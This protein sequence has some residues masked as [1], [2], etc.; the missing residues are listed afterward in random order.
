MLPTTARRPPT[1]RSTYICLSCRLHSNVSDSRSNGE[2]RPRKT[3]TR[4][5]TH[6]NGSTERSEDREVHS[7][8]AKKAQ[9]AASARQRMIKKREKGFIIK[10]TNASI[11]PLTKLFPVGEKPIFPSSLPLQRSDGQASY[12]ERISAAWLKRPGKQWGTAY[13]AKEAEML[14]ERQGG[15]KEELM[16][17]HREMS[18]GRGAE[19]RR[20]DSVEWEEGGTSM[21]ER[22]A[23]EYVERH[24]AGQENAWSTPLFWPTPKLSSH[25]R[26]T[27]SILD[28]A[29]TRHLH[30]S[31]CRSQEA[32]AA[33]AAATTTIPEQLDIPPPEPKKA[34]KIRT[35]LRQ[36][37][38]Q[39]GN[40]DD[41]KSDIDFD[42]DANTA[43]TSN[44]LT[45][46]PD[47]EA[48]F[49]RSDLEEKEEEN[50]SSYA[51][52]PTTDL[53][54][55]TLDTRF[56]QTGDLVELE[57]PQSERESILA[58]FV[59]RL[60]IESQFFTM[61]GRWVH[62]PER[63]VQYSI[64]G[65][66][67]PSLVAPLLDHLPNPST[68]EEVA[69]VKEIAYVQDLSVPR[70]LAAPL[71]SRMVAF[72]TE[73]LEIYRKHAGTLDNAHE[74]LAHETDLRY[75]SLIAAATT[76]L[77][78]PAEKLPVTALFTVRKALG[79]AGF[80]F[81]IDRR[82]HRLT[83]Y[84]QIRSKEQVKMVE[85]V[86]GW[87]REWQDDLAARSAL[88]AEGNERALK[89]HSTP[90]SALYV[91][92]FIEK[93]K[94]IIA[95]SRKDR[96]VTFSGNVGPSKKRFPITPH[97]D[98]V[99]TFKR[100]EFDEQDTE[101][102]R[103]M[104]AWCCS[105]MF[106]DLP[107]IAALPPLILQATGLYNSQE[108]GVATGYQF[109]QELGTIMPYENRVAFDQ[110]LLLP[111]SQH[112]KPLQNLMTSLLEMQDRH[113]FSDSMRE[114]RHD[115]GELSVYCIDAA[116]AHEIDDGLSIQ[117]ASGDEW[118]V[119]V[120]I[121]NPTAFFERDHPLAKMARHMG[122]SIYMPERAYMMLPRW[123]TSR[124]FSLGKN[125]PCLTFSARVNREGETLE[126]SIRP[127]YI[128]NV[129]RLTPE[130]VG[131]LTGD[132]AEGK[133]EEVVLTVGGDVPPPRPRKDV[134][135]SVTEAQVEE[136]KMLQK[137]AGKRSDI[138]R[139]SGGVFFD[140]HRPDIEVWQTYKNPGLPWDHPYRKGSRTVEGD[141]VIQ[142]RTSEL[143]NWFSPR[144]RTVDMMVRECM[145]LACEI[146]AKWCADR[147]IPAIF[148]GTTPRP[149]Q[150]DPDHYLHEILEPASAG[151]EYPMHLGI[152]YLQSLGAPKLSTT[153]LNHRVLGMDF[154][155]KV[156]SPLR[157]Y[158]DMIL[159][160]QIEGALREE[161]RQGKSLVTENRNADRSFLPFSRGVLETIMLGLQPRE[162]IISRA[163][164]YAEA[165]WISMLLFRGLHYG[166]CE[167]PFA[168][169]AD[170]EDMSSVTAG[171]K[172]LPRVFIHTKNSRN[173]VETAC[174]S[175]EL[176]INCSMLRPEKFGLK[177]EVRMGDV[178]ECVLEKVDT[179]RRAAVMRPVRLLE[180]PEFPAFR[181]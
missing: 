28:N 179:Y 16:G 21:G 77:K 161:A 65:W 78:M 13:R 104:E 100:T 43:E 181:A 70:E 175:L 166:E 114:L 129:M 147:Q 164:Y 81:N 2:F 79:R 26:T 17:R 44:N 14:E 55:P 18:E 71:V 131:T 3:T 139:R 19:D 30:T 46:L 169:P 8:A 120:H 146:A 59:R 32:A 130:E 168:T 180:R 142:M 112:S 121:A 1:V 27:V 6:H 64:P 38:E 91:R 60:G 150:P 23:A 41:S 107:R 176:N 24:D 143:V 157:R 92:S 94:S 99:R 66:V 125:R 10:K 122:E 171:T 117:R 52:S 95:K 154:Y 137:L 47:L 29:Q 136:L 69:A 110:H 33:A 74:I 51:H 5:A 9:P 88:V 163:K 97:S 15:E 152:E 53:D 128:R 134:L 119:H 105:N 50:L 63:F 36:W 153:P 108:K 113:N 80:A 159:H 148:R 61:H 62:N 133:G 67:S 98:S 160:W 145:L 37:Q 151:G 135:G 165:F 123:A 138:R 109:L 39:H 162:S 106:L 177:E 158:G 132:G 11:D 103:F 7:D 12:F 111:S 40:K 124:H 73:A 156:T 126:R 57:F 85:A 172:P 31:C 87:L 82:S 72:H 34:S 84:L 45:R 93:A 22:T 178:W 90:R 115:W 25:F 20:V 56:L 48:S 35:Q 144:T 116:S 127:G 68:P 86:R 42:R 101:L 76:L 149:D 170:T 58:V 141:P 75:G 49:R 96:D 173:N 54:T 102:V 118:W 140:L 4:P 174:Q 89:R 155:G 167:L 83:G